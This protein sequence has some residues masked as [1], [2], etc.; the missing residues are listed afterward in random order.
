MSDLYTDP[1]VTSLTCDQPD[2][3]SR[4]DTSRCLRVVAEP[5]PNTLVHLADI[6]DGT[7]ADVQ[8]LINR[9]YLAILMGAGLDAIIV[10]PWMRDPGLHASSSSTMD[11]LL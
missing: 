9:T 7:S 4:V 2:A 11:G 10:D 1:F 8:G 6:S 5:V 3:S